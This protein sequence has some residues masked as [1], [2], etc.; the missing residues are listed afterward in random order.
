MISSPEKKHTTEAS[1]YSN[2]NVPSDVAHLLHNGRNHHTRDILHV[3]CDF[4]GKVKQPRRVLHGL[5]GFAEDKV[6]TIYTSLAA[7]PKWLRTALGETACQQIGCTESRSTVAETLPLEP[8]RDES[9]NVEFGWNKLLTVNSPT[10]THESVLP[11]EER[12]WDGSEK[13]R[14]TITNS[15]HWRTPYDTCRVHTQICLGIAKRPDIW[16]ADDISSLNC[17]VWYCKTQPKLVQDF[18]DHYSYSWLFFTN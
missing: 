3:M 10:G 4:Y 2:C 5:S 18:C 8:Y 9:L 17:A 12:C 11:I 15:N 1:Q 7:H 16:R 6:D 14:H 13:T